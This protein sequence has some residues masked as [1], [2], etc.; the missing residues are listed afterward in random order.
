MGKYQLVWSNA[1]RELSKGIHLNGNTK[2]FYPYTVNP[3]LSPT[4]A[5]LS[6]T[7]LRWSLRE[8]RGLFERAGGV[9]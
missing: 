9:F 5:Y 6:Q 4:G 8:T 3:L 1:R 2:G 7:H